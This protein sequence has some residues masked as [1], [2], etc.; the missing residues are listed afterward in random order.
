MTIFDGISLFGGLALFLYGMRVMGDGLKKGSSSAL[1]AALEK[2]TNNPLMGFLLGLVI[3][4]VIQSS[5]AT[6]VLTSGMVGAGLLTL[7]QS[8]G[9]I[10]GANVG[11][12]ATAQII[13]LLDVDAAATSWTNL[14]KPSTLA[15]LAALIGIL[16]LMAV[17]GQRAETGGSI[18][19]GFGI[20][21]T[22]LLNMTAAV[23]PLCESPLF[24]RILEEFSRIPVLGFLTGAV[25]AFLLHSSSATVGIL[26]AMAATGI[27]AFSSIYSIII[28]VNFG[29][30][31]ST[32]LFCSIG[33]KANAKRTGVVFILFNIFGGTIIIAA[34]FLA[35]Q[36]GLLD[37]LWARTMTSGDIANVHTLFRLSTAVLLLPLV[38]VFEHLSYTIIKDDKE[39]GENVDRE[40]ELLNDKFFASPSLALSSIN[41]AITT[42]GRLARE[43][44]GQAMGTLKEFD[45]HTIDVINENEDHIDQLADAVDHYM[46]RLSPY[47]G[48]ASDNDRL[49]YYIQC[50]SEFE[51]IGDHAVNLTENAA[52]LHEQKKVYSPAAQRELTIMSEAIQEILTYAYSAFK[53]ID[54]EAAK[55]VEPVE[56]V[57]DE[58]VATLRSN[59]IK[60]LR[61]GKCSTYAGL[62]FLD[63]LVNVERIA[64]QCSNLGMYVIA[65]Q[66]GNQGLNHHEY[67]RYLHQGNDTFFNE[68]FKERYDYYFGKLARAAAE[69]ETDQ[70]AISPEQA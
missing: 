1:K 4:A 27:L 47:L 28:G 19:M 21:F 59:H 20:L 10:L 15:P 33:S 14:F 70:A 53:A 38:R 30:C 31:I 62:T 44:V 51:R 7:R 56:E 61:E 9:I 16:L 69:G 45:Q 41:T 22:G 29:E 13:R 43:A 11:T 64:D 50:F 24:I 2:V 63:M 12:T 25:A 57:I 39:I 66:P 49:N 26:Q 54:L 35:R 46:V 67:T 18:A 65:Q 6:I 3:T 42:M 52:E 58:L 68:M 23:E 60:R 37:G 8:I 32:A 40:L 34:L 5:T 55:R 17:K 48:S 36:T